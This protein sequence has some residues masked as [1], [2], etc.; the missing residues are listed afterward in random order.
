MNNKKTVLFIFATILCACL[1]HATLMNASAQVDK[2]YWTDLTTGKIVR[3]DIDGTD[4]TELVTG[5]S[6][7]S[8]IALDVSA[9]KI[10]WTD[11]GFGKIL[12]ANLDGSD[13]TDVLTGLSKPTAIALTSSKIYWTDTSDYKIYSANLDGSQSNPPCLER[14][15]IRYRRDK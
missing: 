9:G 13:E 2:I 6:N 7:P 14:V 5:L 8:G 12:A 1:M 15:I 4:K 3:T 11:Q 10:Y